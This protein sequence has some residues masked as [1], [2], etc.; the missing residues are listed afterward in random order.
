[1]KWEFGRQGTGY[2]KFKVF[3]IGNSF[4]GG[5]DLYILK[6]SKGDS[7]PPHKDPVKGKRHYR[8]NIEVKS[9]R[10]GGELYVEAPILRFG[11]VSFF[12]SDLST[13]AVHLVENGTRYV[14]SLGVAI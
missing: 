5:M 4:F 2:K 8:L 11:P 13:H 6:Y 7:I 1:M 14:V 3:Q 12:R 10:S 9:A